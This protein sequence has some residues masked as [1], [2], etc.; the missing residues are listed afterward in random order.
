MD[1]AI[2]ILLLVPPAVY[3]GFAIAV[4]TAFLFHVFVGHRNRTG[5]YYLPFSIFGFL[6][7]AT[8]A[9]RFGLNWFVYG[10]LALL[11]GLTGAILALIMAHMLDS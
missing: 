11:A 6:G 2:E 1:L 3:L 10:D 7:G 4:A 5:M 9:S 8:F